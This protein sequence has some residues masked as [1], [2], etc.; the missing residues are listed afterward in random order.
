VVIQ[1]ALAVTF[2]FGAVREAMG[3]STEFMILSRIATTLTD[4]EKRTGSSRFSRSICA[5]PWS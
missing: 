5:W 3:T 4:L 1:V 2:I